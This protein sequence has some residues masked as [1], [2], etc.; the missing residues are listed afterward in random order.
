[1]MAKS[2]ITGRVLALFCAVN[3]M[4]PAQAEM[5]DKGCNGGACKDLSVVWI[6]D[7][8]RFFNEG[9]KPL[10]LEVRSGQPGDCGDLKITDLE[11][12]STVFY[13]PETFCGP[14]KANYRPGGAR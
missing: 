6:N 1:M 4:P 5:P 10:R 11:P 14:V 3:I 8:F 9:A 7:G 2:A 12:G 13:G